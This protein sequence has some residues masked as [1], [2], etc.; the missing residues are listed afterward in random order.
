MRNINGVITVTWRPRCPP[1]LIFH[2]LPRERWERA[3][4][5]TAN[6]GSSEPP[7]RPAPRGLSEQTAKHRLYPRRAANRD[8]M[9]KNC[10]AGLAITR[11]AVSRRQ[12]KSLR[13]LSSLLSLCEP[14]S[15]D[16][17]AQWGQGQLPGGRAEGQA[18]VVAAVASGL[19]GG[20]RRRPAG[21]PL[22]PET[23]ARVHLPG[24]TCWGHGLGTPVRTHQLGQPL[25]HTCHGPP[26]GGISRGSPGLGAPRLALWVLPVPSSLPRPEPSAGT[27]D[28]PKADP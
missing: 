10:Q 19:G 12:D 3:P 11:S 28:R 4:K 26:A 18:V 25:G 23:P 21:A 13:F 7:L 16:A 5:S 8:K 20:W 17:G 1:V 22:G 27:D 6:N 15:W 9:I 24:H 2:R 14:L